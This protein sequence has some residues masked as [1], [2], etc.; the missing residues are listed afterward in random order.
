MHKVTPRSSSS[1]AGWRDLWNR[2][3]QD[4]SNRTCY[5]DAITHSRE[6]GD[7]PS[8]HEHPVRRPLLKPRRCGTAISVPGGLGALKSGDDFLAALKAINGKRDVALIA[9]TALPRACLKLCAGGPVHSFQAVMLAQLSASLAA[10][11]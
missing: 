2:A 1:G 9:I 7:G 8:K 11:P 10:S 5:V 4:E 6:G 3:G